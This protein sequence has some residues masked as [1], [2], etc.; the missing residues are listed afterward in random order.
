MHDHKQ[1]FY[2]CIVVNLF[3]ELQMCTLNHSYTLTIAFLML[4]NLPVY[5]QNWH[6]PATNLVKFQFY[7][8]I[9]IVIVKWHCLSTPT[10]FIPLLYGLLFFTGLRLT[11][12]DFYLTLF[13]K[14][15]TAQIVIV[16][17]AKLLHPIIINKLH[18]I[19]L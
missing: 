12:R 9:W 19:I 2:L 10:T 15:A 1:V 3:F 7:C 18:K 17:V 14:P 13:L 16:I 8:Y 5:L 11:S 6:N 4:C